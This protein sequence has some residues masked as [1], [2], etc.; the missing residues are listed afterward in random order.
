MILSCINLKSM[1]KPSGLMAVFI[2]AYT[3][4]YAQLTVKGRVIDAGTQLPVAGAT[5]TTFG[6]HSTSITDQK[7][8]FTL[9]ANEPNDS[10]RISAIGYATNNIAV[11]RRDMLVLLAP[12]FTNLDEVVVTGSREIQKR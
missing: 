5:V 4:F 6:G 9:T 3:P 7:G 2:M 12:T 11:T 8:I 10:L 1:I